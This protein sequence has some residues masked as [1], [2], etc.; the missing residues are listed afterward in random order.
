MVYDKRYELVPFRRILQRRISSI[1]CTSRLY[2][3]TVELGSYSTF[4]AWGA[5]E[6]L[7]PTTYNIE[8]VSLSTV[9]GSVS[10]WPWFGVGL[11]LHDTYNLHTYLPICTYMYV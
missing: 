8:V 5:H 10:D 2:R 3:N 7:L 6:T 11:V 4:P 1:K 9:P